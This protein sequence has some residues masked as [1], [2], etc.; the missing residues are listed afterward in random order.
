MLANVIE[1]LKLRINN[2]YILMEKSTVCFD[3]SSQKESGGRNRIFT[4]TSCL[5]LFKFGKFWIS[6]IITVYKY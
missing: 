6:L 1:D 2:P 4:T 5:W 3:P